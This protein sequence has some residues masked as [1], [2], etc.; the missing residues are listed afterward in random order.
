MD[1]LLILNEITTYS[2]DILQRR[3]VF[4]RWKRARVFKS[5]EQQAI[6]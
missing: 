5:V 1:D 3:G 6:S 4:F 2:I